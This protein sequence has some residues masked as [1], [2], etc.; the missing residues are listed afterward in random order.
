MLQLQTRRQAHLPLADVEEVVARLLPRAVD[1]GERM[2]AVVV[3]HAPQRRRPAPLGEPGL[4]FI[5]I[6]DH[7][8]D[9]AVRALDDVR[10]LARRQDLDAPA[11]PRLGPSLALRRRRRDTR[12]RTATPR[13]RRSFYAGA[14]KLMARRQTTSGARFTRCVRKFQWKCQRVKCIGKRVI[15]GLARFSM[16]HRTLVSLEHARYAVKRPVID[17]EP[18]PH[19]HWLAACKTLATA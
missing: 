6:R 8:F 5:S 15:G 2:S 14:V 10:R 1:W 4:D 16:D 11:G 9:L 3:E 19:A 12:A 18:R 7:L 17:L 13:D